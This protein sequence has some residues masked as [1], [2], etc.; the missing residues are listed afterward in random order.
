MKRNLMN[1]AG[2]LALSLSL[3]VTALAEAPKFNAY[4][5]GVAASA[6]DLVSYFPEGGSKPQKGLLSHTF[7]YQ[8][9]TYRFA[10]K[11]NLEKFKANPEKYVPAYG[12]WCAW[13]IGALN[14]DVDVDPTSFLVRNG[15]LQL[16]Y[17]DAEVD[18]RSMWLKDE[19]AL[20]PKAETN[21]KQRK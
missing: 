1:F 14:K 10:S 11:A 2:A 13:A 16:F 3:A 9:H 19:A 8:G 7:E 17:K 20:A 4:A 6:Y 5:N 12:G 15:R 18:T 21:W